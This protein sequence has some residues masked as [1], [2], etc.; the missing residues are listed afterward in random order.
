[1]D[2]PCQCEKCLL[3]TLVHL[4]RS[5]HEQVDAQL[6]GELARLL[7]CNL[8][9]V[10]QIRLGADEDLVDI[11]RDILVDIRVPCAD[12][13]VWLLGPECGLVARTALTVEGK[14]VRDIVH[15]HDAHSSTPTQFVDGPKLLLS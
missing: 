4:C 2:E 3:D 9:L 12:I 5:L 14:F 10:R 1:M 11:F 13:C 15:Q 6:I 7:L 8:P